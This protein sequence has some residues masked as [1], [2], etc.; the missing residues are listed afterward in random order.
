M[1]KPK[2]TGDIVANWMRLAKGKQTVAFSAGVEH[3]KHIADEFIAAGVSAAWVSGETPKAQREAIIADWRAGYIQ[4][5][6]NCL[7]MTE[8]FDYP[9]LECCILARPTQSVGMF[10]QCAGR[11]MRPAPGKTSAI[12]IDHAG[13]CQLHGQPHMHREWTLEGMAKKRKAKDDEAGNLRVC[14]AC[15]MAYESAPALWLEETQ[16]RL[17]DAFKK[18]ASALFRGPAK[19]RAMDACP[20]CGAA[21]CKVCTSTFEAKTAKREIDGIAWDNACSC[22]SCLAVYVDSPHLNTEPSE[23]EIPDTTDDA[24]IAM[25]DDVP[26][27]VTV[28]NDYKRLLNEAK[29]RGRKRGWAYWRLREKYDEAVIKDCLPRHTGSWWKA[30][31]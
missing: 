9:G 8:G 16:P 14:E 1:D 5:V 10:L 29:Q 24:L 11:I 12:I 7:I 23:T 18:N 31:A 2:L 26:I 22:P 15:G 27:K 17:R 21:S 20:S 25:G 28:L 6:A 19:G 13:S 30:Q 3:A 4:V